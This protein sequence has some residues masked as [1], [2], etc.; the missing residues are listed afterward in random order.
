MEKLSERS[1]ITSKSAV[2]Y[3]YEVVLES[4]IKVRAGAVIYTGNGR[5][6]FPE[7]SELETLYEANMKEYLS[8]G[9]TRIPPRIMT[10]ADFMKFINSAKRPATP[11][12]KKRIA[13]VGAGDSGKAVLRWLSR[14]ADNQSYGRDRITVGRPERIFWYGQEC[15]SCGEFLEK[16][17]SFYSDIAGVFKAQSKTPSD[18]FGNK[19]LIPKNKVETVTQRKAAASSPNGVEKGDPIFILKPKEG[20]RNGSDGRI[21]KKRKVAKVAKKKGAKKQKGVNPRSE[22]GAVDYIIVTTGF[23]NPLVDIFW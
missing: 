18:A 12:E 13:I 17:R 1:K 3:P 21:A 7:G 9:D 20:I 2:S 5:P 23:E 15:S 4:G 6:T 22:Q 19:F 16:N 8:S 10:Y 14:Q 11:F